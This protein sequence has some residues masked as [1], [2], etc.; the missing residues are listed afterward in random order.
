MPK[1]QHGAAYRGL[2]KILRDLRENV[3]LTQR[4]LGR[5]MKKPQ[6]WIYNCESGNRRMDI[7]EFIAWCRA[8]EIEPT[9]AFQQLLDH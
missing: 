5:R 4:E 7:T 2:R 8:C 1:A 9:K 6:S 3:A